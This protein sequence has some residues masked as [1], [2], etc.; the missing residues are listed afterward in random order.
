MTQAQRNNPINDIAPLFIILLPA[1]WVCL[2][3]H[4][5]AALAGPYAPAPW[6]IPAILPVSGL[7]SV[8]FGIIIN[9]ERFGVLARLRELVVLLILVWV[10]T[11]LFGWEDFSSLITFRAANVWPCIALFIF[12]FIQLDLQSLFIE[13]AR[14]QKFTR[15]RRGQNLIQFL[16]E[17]DGI[18]ESARQRIKNIKK[19]VY[20]LIVLSIATVCLETLSGGEGSPLFYA[21]LAIFLVSSTL[22]LGLITHWEVEYRLNFD[23]LKNNLR[24]D[25]WHLGLIAA[26]SLLALALAGIFSRNSSFFPESWLRKFFA[27]LNRPPHGSVKELSSQPLEPTPELPALPFKT[28]AGRERQLPQLDLSAI[29]TILRKLVP[30]SALLSL[31]YFVIRPLLQKGSYKLLSRYPPRK[32]LSYLINS[33]RRLFSRGPWR[34]KKRIIK[35]MEDSALESVHKFLHDLRTSRHSLPKQRQLG[36]M[37]DSFLNFV[38]WGIK[39]GCPWRESVGPHEYGQKLI[40]FAQDKTDEILFIVK[41][42]E[43]AVYSSEL[44]SKRIQDEYIKSIA[45]LVKDNE[46]Y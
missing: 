9:F 3:S 39:R 14:Y 16:R 2:V 15:I 13:H 25:L 4:F 36:R 33:V 7:F 31:F 21:Y 40:P 26:L 19:S 34:R 10:G 28:P 20:L 17:N 23:G 29:W 27:W 45:R 5:I 44:V 35:N 41:T 1:S 38:K 46:K 18:Q 6:L 42:F 22:L 12:W 37:T 8:Y 32:I 30:L 24:A 43:I 11:S